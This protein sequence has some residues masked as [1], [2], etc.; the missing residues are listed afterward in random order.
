[1]NSVVLDPVPGGFSMH[2]IFSMLFFFAEPSEAVRS[3]Q[4]CWVEED[5]HSFTVG[6][7]KPF[8]PFRVL[9]RR[10][11]ECDKRPEEEAVGSWVVSWQAIV[12]TLLLSIIAVN[13]PLQ[14][15]CSKMFVQ[16]VIKTFQKEVNSFLSSKAPSSTSC[17][18]KQ[19]SGPIPQCPKA[20]FVQTTLCQA[21]KL[22][23]KLLEK[24]IDLLN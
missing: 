16:I 7:S 15:L 10:E 6:A 23:S 21:K 5:P 1:M 3:W 13:G 19:P 12:L 2:W 22:P 8:A 14:L 20:N 24:V 18:E 17:Y 11:E 4:Q 9:P